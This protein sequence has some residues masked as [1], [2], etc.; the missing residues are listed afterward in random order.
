MELALLSHDDLFCW[1]IGRFGEAA[2]MVHDMVSSLA[3]ARV[4]SVARAMGKQW[5]DGDLSKA[6]T[7]I[8]QNLSVVSVRSQSECLLSRMLLVGPGANQA[9]S[10]RHLAVGQEERMRRER[11]AHFLAKVTGRQII[12]RGRFTGQ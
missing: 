10:R 1:V 4:T 3:M 5:T 12:R 9:A 8:R 2:S 11:A 6:I 7:Q